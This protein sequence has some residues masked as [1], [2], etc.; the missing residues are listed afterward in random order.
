MEE[1]GEALLRVEIKK[2]LV[3]VAKKALIASA[4]PFTIYVLQEVDWHKYFHRPLTFLGQK[5]NKIIVP[6]NASMTKEDQPV[7]SKRFEAI[8]Q[9][10]RKLDYDKAGVKTL[11]ENPKLVSFTPHE[12]S[13]LFRPGVFGN[14]RSDHVGVE[15]SF[16]SWLTLFDQAQQ[17]KKS[18]NGDQINIPEKFVA[19]I[20]SKTWTLEALQVLL[21]TWEEEYNAKQPNQIHLHG[22]VS[23]SGA[24]NFSER[25]FAVIHQMEK[26]GMSSKGIKALTHFCVEEDK[27]YSYHRSAQEERR[28]CENFLP[29][30]V[31]IS[32]GV[33]ANA[34]IEKEEV[35]VTISSKLLSVVELAALIETWEQEYLEFTQLEK[36]LMYF[37]FK[38]PNREQ[39]YSSE[40]LQFYTEFLFDSGKH[41]SN[42]FFP[43]K[44]HLVKKI[45]FFSENEAW[46]LDRGIPYMFGLLLHGEP[47]CG[48][49]SVIKAIAN[50][51]KRHIISIPLKNVDTISDLYHALY[52]EKVDR[53]TI[54]LSKR[55]YV[56]EDIDC[57][58]L[59]DIVK[60]RKA[61]KEPEEQEGKNGPS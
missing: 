3:D 53:R 37:V 40:P 15:K 17:Q 1:T 12:C 2:A 61:R 13:F 33:S 43:E 44:E 57:G 28:K 39:R 22:K 7:P 49:T 41:F 35:T 8:M 48:K 14:I 24:F 11:L 26:K 51:T 45:N 42:V 55:L 27:R 10:V 47:G 4:I 29:E 31:E 5:T 54:P 34:T 50:L 21:S 18:N 20:Y 25:L 56:F 32:E 16:A 38:S 36:G 30:T 19:E 9:Q 52:H 6:W 60:G 59:E 46:Y 23:N 58:G